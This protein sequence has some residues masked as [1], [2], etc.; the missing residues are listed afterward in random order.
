MNDV[1]LDWKEI[2]QVRR[3]NSLA[4]VLEAHQDVFIEELGKIN[5]VKA[6]IEVDPQASPRFCKARPV[7]FVLRRKVEEELKRLEELGYIKPRKFVE[8]DS[9]SDET[10]RI[11]EDLRR[12]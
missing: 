7:L 3:A 8:W 9:P 6:K 10:K 5:E 1:R 2:F 12:L 4:A 11:S